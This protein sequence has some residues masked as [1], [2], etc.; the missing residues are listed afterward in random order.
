MNYMT[1]AQITELKELAKAGN[2]WWKS[3]D[4]AVLRVV[5]VKMNWV[6]F[7]DEPE[8][9]EPAAMLAG[10]VPVS[11]YNEVP[12]AFFVMEPLFARPLTTTALA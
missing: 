4:G 2:V 10:S 11:L 5:G 12:D 7:P 6:E 1:D 9:Q 3:A 8:S